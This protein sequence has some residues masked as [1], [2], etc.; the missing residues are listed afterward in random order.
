MDTT[1]SS[2]TLRKNAKRAAEAMIR[3]GT[4]PAVNYDINPSDNGRF[5]I[6]WKTAKAAPTTDEVEIEIAEASAGQPAAASPTEAASQPA[7]A[8]TEP[9]TTDAAPQRASEAEAASQ[10]APVA[11]EPAPALSEPAP[12][13]EWPAGTRVMVRKR[14]SW[15]EATI[16]SRLD[17]DHWRAEY[18]G[19]GSGMFREADIRGYDP[20]RDATPAKQPRCAKARRRKSCRSRDIAS[21]RRRS[22][23]G[24]YPKGHR[25]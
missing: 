15:R 5:E 25:S 3:K 8:A 7:P 11:T 24:G 12:K 20:K 6:V 2:F 18:L 10:P 21:T 23:P 4:A 13:N 9:A 16:I 14:K 19:G 17:P 22:P 1:A